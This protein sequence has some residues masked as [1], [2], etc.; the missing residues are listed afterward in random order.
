M[1]WKFVW[2]NKTERLSR[3]LMVK[4]VEKGG[5]NAPDFRL[6]VRASKISWMKKPYLNPNPHCGKY[7]FYWFLSEAQL[8][9]DILKSNY[10]LEA[11]HLAALSDFYA[12]NVRCLVNSWEYMFQEKRNVYMV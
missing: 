11:K 5:L 2:D 6:M 4:P 8:S 12:Q 1:I 9:P 10:K 3:K 7:G